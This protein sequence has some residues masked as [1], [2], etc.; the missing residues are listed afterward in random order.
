[1]RKL[2][3]STANS[4]LTITA[5][6]L[7][8]LAHCEDGCTVTSDVL[9]E[10]FGTSP[11]VIR[12]VLAKLKRAG[13][14]KS[15]SGAGGGS[16]LAKPPSEITLRD[17]YTAITD[18]ASTVLVRQPGGC[19]DGIDIAPVIAEYFNE[20]FEDAEQALLKTLSSVNISDLTQEISKRLNLPA[21]QTSSKR[22]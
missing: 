12:R 6:I 1:M 21:P 8:V 5:H 18:D 7:A 4:Q 13:L 17:A 16:I 11:V 14:V 10:G 20:L 19:K 3:N 9:A 2:L 22:K 15:K